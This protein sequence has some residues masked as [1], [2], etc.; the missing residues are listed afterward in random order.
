MTFSIQKLREDTINQVDEHLQD[1]VS[2]IVEGIQYIEKNKYENR[3]EKYY[4]DKKYV[5]HL[6]NYYIYK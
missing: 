4:N 2:K 1:M 6:H 3:Y 5:S